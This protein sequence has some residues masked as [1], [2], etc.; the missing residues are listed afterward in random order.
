MTEKIKDID[1]TGRNY[2][3]EDLTTNLDKMIV[4]VEDKFKA[5]LMDNRKKTN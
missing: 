4:F 5:P 2:D 1:T 3:L